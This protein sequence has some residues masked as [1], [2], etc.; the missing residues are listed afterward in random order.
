MK[1]RPIPFATGIVGFLMLLRASTSSAN[2]CGEVP[3]ERIRH[4]C[5]IV[6]NQ[7]GE[8]IPNTELTLLKGGSE[9]VTIQAGPDGKFEFGR[10]EAGNYEL[11]AHFDGYQTVRSPIVIVRPT[12]KCN[13]G[14]EVTLPVTACGGGI[15]KAK[16]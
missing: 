10:V 3:P 9:L 8:R 16:R 13:R 6:T 11:R 7:V 4:V 5:G 14:L 2:T 15:G 12:T 1:L